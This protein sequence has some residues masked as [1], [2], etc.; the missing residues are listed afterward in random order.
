V[1][2]AR[3]QPLEHVVFREVSEHGGGE[4]DA[5][6]PQRHRRHE[7]VE[8][9]PQAP[10]LELVETRVEAAS[11]ATSDDDDLPRRTKPRRRRGG[12]AASEPLMMVETKDAPQPPESPTSP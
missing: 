9:I 5:H 10:Q 12:P 7:H 11:A 2:L 4:D 3:A 6:R 1:P 8:G